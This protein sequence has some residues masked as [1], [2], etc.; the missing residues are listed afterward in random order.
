MRLVSKNWR[1]Y[2]NDL[3]NEVESVS[4]SAQTTE[5]DKHLRIAPVQT[6]N[7]T[8]QSSLSPLSLK[9]QP[10]RV[11]HQVS[12]QKLPQASTPGTTPG[13][14]PG[15]HQVP[16]LSPSRIP[17]LEPPELPPDFRHQ[18][19]PFKFSDVQ[20][21]EFLQGKAQKT[22]LVLKLHLEILE[23]LRNQYRLISSDPLFP[24]ELSRDC[25]LGLI[26]FFKGVRG[27]EKTFRK[28]LARAETVLKLLEN[29]K[30]LVSRFLLH[31]SL[32][33]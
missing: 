29:C 33:Y 4:T 8:M 14:I 16:P 3:E 12:I 17:R 13:S 9:N 7:Q 32:R 6:S 31:E 26:K 5:I 22:L 15:P 10:K 20:R 24:E 11:P 28:Q 23:D 21:I 27:I 2:I 18:G 19:Q 1:W 25:R 30:N